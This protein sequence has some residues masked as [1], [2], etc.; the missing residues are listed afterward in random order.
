MTYREARSRAGTD[1]GT[2]PDRTKRSVRPVRRVDRQTASVPAATT[3][4]RPS[5]PGVLPRRARRPKN[6]P[7]DLGFRDSQPGLQSRVPQFNSGR[8]LNERE[9]PPTGILPG[10]GHFFVSPLGR[11]PGRY[12]RWVTIHRTSATVRAAVGLVTADWPRS[13]PDRVL[14][15]ESIRRLATQRRGLGSKTERFRAFIY[16]AVD[17]GM[18]VVPEGNRCPH[19]GDL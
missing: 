5:A 18:A 16:L 10:Q 11:R 17:S 8:R 1:S 12:R 4:N 2:R 19:I 7:S 9:V 14:R 13:A 15:R 6:R 3:R